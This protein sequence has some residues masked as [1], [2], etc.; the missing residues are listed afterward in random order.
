MEQKHR[1]QKEYHDNEY[2]MMKDGIAPYSAEVPRG[3][4]Y[5]LSRNTCCNEE[6]CNNKY[7]NLILWTWNA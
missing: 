1:E 2:S 7:F 3:R 6:C 4:K 5:N